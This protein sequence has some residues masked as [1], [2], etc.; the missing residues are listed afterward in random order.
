M[1]DRKRC[2]YTVGLQTRTS[3]GQNFWMNLFCKQIQII[4]YKLFFVIMQPIQNSVLLLRH[5][6]AR[7]LDQLWSVSTKCVKHKVDP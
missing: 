2:G 5:K 3:W 1:D 4:I 6:K 7:A